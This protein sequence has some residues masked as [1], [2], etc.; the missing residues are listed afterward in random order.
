MEMDAAAFQEST[1]DEPVWN[2]IKR[3][4]GLVRLVV[5]PSVFDVVVV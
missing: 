4:L 1:L 5:I 3:D 2:T